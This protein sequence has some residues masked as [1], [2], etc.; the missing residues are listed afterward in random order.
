MSVKPRIFRHCLLYNQAS[1][2]DIINENYFSY[3][4][5]KTGFMYSKELSYDSS[6]EHPKQL[7]ELID[8][9]NK[10]QFMLKK[11]ELDL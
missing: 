6:F 2:I 7:C 3:F 5:I 10:I 11:S 4:S 1:R 9:E 8:N